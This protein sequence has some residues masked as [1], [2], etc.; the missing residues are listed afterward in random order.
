VLESGIHNSQYFK[1]TLSKKII[2]KEII[3]M[4]KTASEHID[5]INQFLTAVSNEVSYKEAAENSQESTID[6]STS[7]KDT[8]ASTPEELSKPKAGEFTPE[9]TNLGNE[10]SEAAKDG[11]GNVEEVNE[12]SDADGAA[13]EDDR[14]TQTM[15]TDDPVREDGNIGPI[16]EQA[17]TQEQKVARVQNLGNAI[18]SILKEAEDGEYDKKS[19]SEKKKD[20][21]DKSDEEKEYD[22]KVEEANGHDDL[23]KSAALEA[24]A[25]Y[26][27]AYFAGMQKRAE[28]VAALEAANIDPTILEK[29]GGIE[30][31][32]DKVAMEYPEAVMPE[33]ALDM[34]TDAEV[35]APVEGA[36]MEAGGDLDAIAGELEAAGV[37]PEELEAA[38]ADVQVLQDA[39]IAPEEL[40][41]ALTEMNEEGAEAAAPEMPAAPEAAEETSVEELK[42]ANDRS[43]ID[44]IKAYLSK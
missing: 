35:A 4:N 30:G 39:G 42:E 37:T 5:Q 16:T 8:A 18:L 40:A 14:G 32:L 6:Q 24:G 3:N 33:G 11:G 41:Q 43:R 17:I 2:F 44:A 7:F 1:T 13:F 9:Q 23:M 25:Q 31:L 19:D 10:Q 20:E 12:N 22:D 38:L 36:E 34:A 26:A 15:S 29:V 21:E 27:E 28:D